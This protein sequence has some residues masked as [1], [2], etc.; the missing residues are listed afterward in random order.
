L[1]FRLPETSTYVI[2]LQPES[3]AGALYYLEVELGSVLPLP[4]RGYTV[5]SR[6]GASRDSGRRHHEGVDIFAPRRTPVLAVADG[7]AT[8]RAGKLGGHSIWL[9]APGASYYYAH[10]ERVAVGGGERVRAGDILGYVGDSGNAAS[11][12]PHL[13]FG[14]YKWGS[15]PIDPLPLLEERRFAGPPDA[16]FET[17][18]R[19]GAPPPKC[20][21]RFPDSMSAERVCL[22][23]ETPERP[24][25][26]VAP[27][28]TLIA[29]VTMPVELAPRS[30]VLPPEGIDDVPA[31][32]CSSA[33]AGLP[34]VC[35]VHARRVVT[36]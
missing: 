34:G 8:Y 35:S 1:R 29:A 3:A 16:A 31:L 21:A 12:G 15:E 36:F 18:E 7:R 26:G 9:N 11:V 23:S 13:H 10:L 19:T 33:A 2:R 25:A 24:L 4:V 17:M 32:S 22:A 20:S 14:I 27:P 30:L 6:Y 28:L 5:G